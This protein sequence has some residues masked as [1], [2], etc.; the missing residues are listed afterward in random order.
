MKTLITLSVLQTIGIVALVVHAF[1]EEHPAAPGQH[2]SNSSAVA[3][4]PDTSSR[5]ISAAPDVDEERLRTIIRE[6]LAR[7][8]QPATQGNAAPAV[9]TRPRNPSADA[10]QREVVAQQIEAYAA[11]GAITDMQM[12]ELQAEIAQLDD[13]S[14]KQMMSKLI[15]ALNSGDIKGRL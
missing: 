13:A 2:T 9:A 11:A 7:L 8:I 3:I 10:R 5:V 14:R 1:R 6:E 12:Q 15:R 4:S